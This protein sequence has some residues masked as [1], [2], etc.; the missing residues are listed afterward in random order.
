MLMKW[1]HKDAH[2]IICSRQALCY[3]LALK[4]GTLCYILYDI[5]RFEIKVCLY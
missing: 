1:G 2:Y 5:K 3:L 4:Q